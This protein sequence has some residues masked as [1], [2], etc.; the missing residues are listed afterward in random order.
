MKMWKVL[1]VVCSAVLVV[2]GIAYLGSAPELAADA[3]PTV[4]Q[5]DEH[6]RIVVRRGDGNLEHGGQ[7][8][9]FMYSF[10][11]ETEEYCSGS[12]NCDV[13]ECTGTLG[14]CLEGC[15]LCFDLACGIEAN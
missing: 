5:A 3:P 9:D 8:E 2:A 11:G 14:C 4:S 1:V 7:L 10:P 12:C 15:D 6:Q 13:C